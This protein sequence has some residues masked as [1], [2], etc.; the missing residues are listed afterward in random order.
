MAKDLFKGVIYTAA[1]QIMSLLFVLLCAAFLNNGFFS[2]IIGLCSAFLY[3]GLAVNHALNTAKRDASRIRKINKPYFLKSV[4]L[5]LFSS[6]IPLVLL[7]VLII[8]KYGLI[9]D[10]ML[11]YRLL[12]GYFILITRDMTHSAAS[13]TGLQT[14]LLL[15]AGLVPVPVCAVTYC[16]S[17][18]KLI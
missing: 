3:Y 8:S 2:L 9:K 15:G 11:P 14:A 18:K 7:A 13:V 4:L 12:N 5:G 17:I 10:F 6:L 16:I 1:A